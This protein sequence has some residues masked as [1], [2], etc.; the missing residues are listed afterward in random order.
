M[1]LQHLQES[2][3]TRIT[4]QVDPAQDAKNPETPHFYRHHWHYLQLHKPIHCSLIHWLK[5]IITCWLKA[6]IFYI[7]VLFIRL[8]NNK[9]SCYIPGHRI[10]ILDVKMLT[11][12]LTLILTKNPHTNFSVLR[13]LHM[14]LSV[15]T[16]VFF[17]YLSVMLL[18]NYNTQLI[19]Y[20]CCLSF[21][22]NIVR[23]HFSLPIKLYFRAVSILVY[24]KHCH[25]RNTAIL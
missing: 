18:T 8:I 15:F 4:Q 12:N 25:F 14:G 9:N 5:K 3:L 2:Y 22:E 6:S 23:R 10:W 24:I 13:L 1:S 16:W 17:F 21:I 19:Q 7:I 20:N 11:I